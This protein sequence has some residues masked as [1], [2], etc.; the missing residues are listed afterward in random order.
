M[1]TPSP[2]AFL[3]IMRAKLPA[4]RSQ[5]KSVLKSGVFKGRRLSG[6]SV[7]TMRVEGERNPVAGFKRLFFTDIY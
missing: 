4:L 2:Q 7:L 1:G 3:V 5:K 6:G